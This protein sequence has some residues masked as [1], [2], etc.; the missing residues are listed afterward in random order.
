[1]ARD[2]AGARNPPASA[3]PPAAAPPE[4]PAVDRDAVFTAALAAATPIPVVTIALIAVNI[5]VFA[6]MLAAGVSASNPTSPTLLLWG[7][8]YGPS[9]THGEWWRLI[10]AMF[11]HVG[12]MHLLLNMYVLFAA[13][14]FTER[15]FGSVGTLV[16]YLL[17]GFGG[18]IAGVWWHPLSVAAGASGAIFGLYGGV[19]GY[20]LV[21]RRSMPAGGATSLFANTVAFVVLNL[22]AGGFRE[23]IDVAAHV[24]G[25]ATGAALGCALAMPVGARLSA[26]VRR[27]SLVA[28]TGVAVVA[29]A[30]LRLPAVDDWPVEIG[31]VSAL[32]RTLTIGFSTAVRQVVAGQAAPDPFLRTVLARTLAPWQDERTRVLSLHLPEPERTKARKVA[33]YM[34]LRA[35]AWKTLADG[36]G[37]DDVELIKAA[38]S[39]QEAA[40][41]SLRTVLPARDIDDQLARLRATRA[42]ASAFSDAVTRM[43]AIESR[44]IDGYNDAL[45]RLRSGRIDGTRFQRIV[46]GE[47]L[48]PWNAERQR[49]QALRVLDDQAAPRRVVVDYMTRRAAAWQL[50]ARGI[51]SNDR[52]LVERGNAEDAAA[53]KIAASRSA[54]ALSSQR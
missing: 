32:E 47:L 19:C 50:I 12:L 41:Q 40:L 10:A 30:V 6:T 17:A 3:V 7:A 36:V 15:L 42:A 26:R 21:S 9:L 16:L 11:V 35:A 20:L 23:H 8:T 44:T 27:A 5:A 37:S 53:R 43:A 4:E 29:L 28:A 46:E 38:E 48:P 33:E 24:G 54:I 14:Q 13:G 45:R 18:G 1:L 39:E 51:G 34:T 31:R 25:L 49:L 22:V 2:D 52:A